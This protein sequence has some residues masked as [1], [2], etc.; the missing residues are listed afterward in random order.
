MTCKNGIYLSVD[1]NDAVRVI[2]ENSAENRNYK[3]VERY[4]NSDGSDKVMRLTFD[5]YRDRLDKAAKM[6]NFYLQG[7]VS[8]E[9]FGEFIRTEKCFNAWLESE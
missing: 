6:K 4:E 3:R 2:A 9:E 7:K 8:A 5:E 1:G